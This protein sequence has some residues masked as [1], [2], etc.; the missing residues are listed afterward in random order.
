MSERKKR[1][2][3]SRKSRLEHPCEDVFRLACPIRED[4]WIPGWREQREIIYSKSG[5]AELGCVF[6]TMNIPN[7]MGPA[8]WVN[9]IYEPFDRIQY[10]AMN[11]KLVYQM[12]WN[13]EK[14]KEGC[15]VVMTR[16]WTALTIEAEGFLAIIG[17]T[18]MN[19]PLDLFALIDHY[20]TTGKMMRS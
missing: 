10:S 7:L 2:V 19:K 6:T 12:Q 16:T 9:N 14:V 4:E 17:K 15:E 20:L 3:I 8:T 1:F 5:Y 11:D 18:V 13:L